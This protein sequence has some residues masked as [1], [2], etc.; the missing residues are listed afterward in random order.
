MTGPGPMAAATPVAA[1]IAAHSPKIW[2]G[3]P[4]RVMLAP[5]TESLAEGS[6]R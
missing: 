5:T 6:H 3:T 4:A 1:A 2:T